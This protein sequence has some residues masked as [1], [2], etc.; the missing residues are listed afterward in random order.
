GVQHVR[1]HAARLQWLLAIGGAAGR[2]GHRRR[3][4]G[5]PRRCAERSG[6]PVGR[7]LN[8]ITSGQLGTTESGAQSTASAASVNI[9]NGLITADEVVANVMSSVI[10]DGAF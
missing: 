2:F 7:F 6:R 1:Q 3:R 8:S 9:L 10:Q 5:R 4:S